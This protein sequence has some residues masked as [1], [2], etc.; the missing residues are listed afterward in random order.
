[1]YTLVKARCSYQNGQD[2]AVIRPTSDIQ[3]DPCAMPETRRSSW[4]DSAS[5]ANLREQTTTHLYRIRL[6]QVFLEVSQAPSL[7]SLRLTSLVVD[8]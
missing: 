8:Q 2:H 3:K 5:S 4:M 7:T 6:D 1:M